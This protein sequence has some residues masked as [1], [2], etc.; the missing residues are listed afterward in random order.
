MKEEEEEDRERGRERALRFPFPR[1]AR[2]HSLGLQ[3][4]T[5]MFFFAVAQC[6]FPVKVNGVGEYVR[7]KKEKKIFTGMCLLP[8]RELQPP[9]TLTV[10]VAHACRL[11][12]PPPPPT[13]PRPL[14]C[15]C[16]LLLLFFY[17]RPKMQG[18]SQLVSACEPPGPVARSTLK[19][20]VG[21]SQ[22]QPTDWQTAS[23]FSM[24]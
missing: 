21:F 12:P 10:P 24:W 19:S 2:I 16:L 13:H 7:E 3:P 22:T 11:I 6:F 9:A 18:S 1:S 14:F 20:S 5:T 8:V 17:K 4:A 23:Q 15:C